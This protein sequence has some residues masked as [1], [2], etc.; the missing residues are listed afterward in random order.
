MN[1][2]QSPT[3]LG[4]SLIFFFWGG[5]GELGWEGGEGSCSVVPNTLVSQQFTFN[6]PSNFIPVQLLFMLSPPY[7]GRFQ[8]FGPI[9]VAVA[10][11]RWSLTRGSK[12]SDLTWKLLPF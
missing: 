8:T 7:Q 6:I 11:D 2:K 5:G 3:N 9:V 12:Y 1:T 10:Y 4:L